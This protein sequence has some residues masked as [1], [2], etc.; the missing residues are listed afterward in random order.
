ML[1]RIPREEPSAEMAR[2]LNEARLHLE[3]LLIPWLDNL[4]VMNAS[5]HLVFQ[6]AYNFMLKE[7]TLKSFEGS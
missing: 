6:N 3:R 1:K 7:S 5:Q 2:E 4:L